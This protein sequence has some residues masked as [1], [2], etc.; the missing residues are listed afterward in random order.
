[1]RYRDAQH[2]DVGSFYARSARAGKLYRILGHCLVAAVAVA[3]WRHDTRM[4]TILLPVLVV[5]WLAAWFQVVGTLW[6][7]SIVAGIVACAILLAAA[8]CESCCGACAAGQPAPG[9]AP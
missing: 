8:H 6:R 4:L 2:V 5:V 3:G 7:S 1:M 9:S